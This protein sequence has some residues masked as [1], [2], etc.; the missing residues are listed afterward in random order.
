MCPMREKV[1][2]PAV[3]ACSA[4]Q[5]QSFEHAW[6][7][8]WAEP[9]ECRR[10]LSAGDLD[11]TFSDDGRRTLNPPGDFAQ[12]NDT[13]VQSNGKV[14][15]AGSARNPV[16]PLNDGLL[17][18]LNADGT[19]DTSFDDDGVVQVHVLGDHLTFNAVAIL[20]DGKIITGGTTGDGEWVLARFTAAGSPDTSFGVNGM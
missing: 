9:L 5:V 16:E 10:L 14:V 17:V 3:G 18:R 1:Q 20:P 7:L 4:A 11:L 19:T 6:P 2:P 15:V 13:A 12:A 8:A